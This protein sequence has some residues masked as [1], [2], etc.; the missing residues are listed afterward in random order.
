V[1]LHHVA[2][3]SWVFQ[4]GDLCAGMGCCLIFVLLPVPPGQSAATKDKTEEQARMIER[5]AARM[6]IQGAKVGK[7]SLGTG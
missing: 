3:V 2:D 4:V 1:L 7:G 5:R 6:I